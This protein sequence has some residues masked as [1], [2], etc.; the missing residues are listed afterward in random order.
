MLWA[1]KAYALSDEEDKSILGCRRK[2][3]TSR[4]REVILPLWDTWDDVSSTGLPSTGQIQPYW[5]ECSRG[6]GKLLWNPSYKERLRELW[7]FSLRKKLRVALIHVYTWHEDVK[8]VEKEFLVV[9][10]DRTRGNGLK[11]KYKKFHLHVRKHL[12]LEWTR[13]NTGTGYPRG[14][15]VSILGEIKIELDVV[16]SNL[17]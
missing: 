6:T 2:S 8:K 15:G 16:L 10:N 13:S 3:I 17:V 1:L 14:C 7:L 11:L 12:F 5:S 4:L 9:L